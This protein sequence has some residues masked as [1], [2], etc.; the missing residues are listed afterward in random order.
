LKKEEVKAVYD[1]SIF[2]SIAARR[3]ARAKDSNSR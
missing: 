1:G 3:E 2:Y